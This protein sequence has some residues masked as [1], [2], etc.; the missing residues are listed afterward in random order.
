LTPRAEL[1]I[2]TW[3]W[4]LAISWAGERASSAASSTY[5]TLWGAARAE[6]TTRGA[7]A[8]G[9]ATVMT[10]EAL[11]MAAEE[12]AARTTILGLAADILRLDSGL[13]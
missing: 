10:A 9:T 7:E 1:S 12:P 2:A 13:I 4:R 6:A 3:L 5:T 8:L 11:G